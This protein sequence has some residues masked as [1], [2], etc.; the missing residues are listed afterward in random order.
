MGYELHITRKKHYWDVGPDI[1]EEEW[2][3][4]VRADPELEPYVELGIYAAKWRG[5]SKYPDPWLDWS[6]GHISSKN[7]DSPLIQKM[8]QVATQLGAKVQGDEGEVYTDPENYYFE[9]ESSSAEAE[10]TG[11]PIEMQPPPF[12]I[13]DIVVDC[14][15]REGRVLR[16]DPTGNGGA[17]EIRVKFN[18]GLESSLWF[19]AHGLEKKNS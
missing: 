13:G 10:K 2:M 8:L 3:H 6:M 12:G 18:S 9:T 15:G 17:G 19:I 4:F 5:K 7:P 11:E 16:I 14:F 1:S